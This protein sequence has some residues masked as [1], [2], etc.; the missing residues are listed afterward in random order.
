MGLKT[1]GSKKAR[2]RESKK[3]DILFMGSSMVHLSGFRICQANKKNSSLAPLLG[4][5]S[6]SERL[7]YK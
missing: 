1:T 4:K 3:E 5:K 2:A 7:V 6:K